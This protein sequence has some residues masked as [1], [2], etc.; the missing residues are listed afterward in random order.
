MT[1]NESRT[2]IFIPKDANYIEIL[3]H[4]IDGF[5][6]FEAFCEHLKKYAELEETV[7]R[8]QAENKSLNAEI[9]L[10]KA[11]IAVYE[12]WGSPQEKIKAE[13]YKEFAEELKKKMV[14]HNFKYADT[15]FS[16]N[17]ATAPMVDNL[18]KEMVGEDK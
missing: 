16:A 5:D 11:K 18:L 14:K 4:K 12:G 9:N 17:V 1:D 2:L 6:S 7:N 8:L 13:A 10:L 15:L 3:G